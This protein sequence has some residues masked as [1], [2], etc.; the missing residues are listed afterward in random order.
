MMRDMDLIRLIVLKVDQNDPNGPIEGYTKDEI[1][2]N[3]MQAIEMGLLKGKVL[4]DS[5]RSTP[6]PANVLLEDLTP[7][8]HDFI[9]GIQSESNWH[10][11]KDYLLAGG[12]QITIETIK[13]AIRALFGAS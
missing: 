5:R 3:C 9:D 8:G 7:A 11:V 6:V 12:K 4:K 1:K 2:Y 10:K 13:A